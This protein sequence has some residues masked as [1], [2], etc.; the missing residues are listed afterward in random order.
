LD[1]ARYIELILRFIISRVSRSREDKEQTLLKLIELLKPF[2]D[3][4]IGK[5]FGLNEIYTFREK[6]IKEIME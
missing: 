2:G 3:R 6:I 5:G 4:S 1:S